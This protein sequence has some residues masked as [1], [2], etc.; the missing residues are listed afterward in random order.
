MP[1]GWRPAD[2]IDKFP[3]PITENPNE[4][5]KYSP[6]Y[7]IF[8]KSIALFHFISINLLLTFFLYNFS[9]LSIEF[10]LMYGFIIAISIFGFTSLMDFQSWALNFE[11]LRSISAIFLISSLTMSK[12]LLTDFFYSYVLMLLYFFLTIVITIFYKNEFKLNKYV[13]STLIEKHV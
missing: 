3:R 13:S 1:T 7:S 5:A 2:V 10:K 8:I 9:D 4:R 6:N 12:F 11:I